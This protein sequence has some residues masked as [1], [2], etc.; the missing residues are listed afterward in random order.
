MAV[1]V[2]V[3]ARPGRAE[4]ALK[5]IAQK[6][7]NPDPILELIGAKIVSH[8]KTRFHKSE[9]PTGRPWKRS[10][11]AQKERRRTGIRT[12]ALLESIEAEVTQGELVVGSDLPYARPFQ[13]GA[14]RR[15]PGAKPQRGLGRLELRTRISL[16]GDVSVKL[17]R[18]G[19]PKPK[20][21][22]R[23]RSYRLPRR[24]FI[25]LS[26]KDRAEILAIWKEQAEAGW[27]G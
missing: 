17:T 20:A 8:T 1:D 23:P 27:K 15:T 13:A 9:T 21:G 10:K 24:P 26:K 11:L 6:V 25:G 2:Q 5:D 19:A 12:G 7:K 16:T 4:K 3:K 22:K 18:S 14:R